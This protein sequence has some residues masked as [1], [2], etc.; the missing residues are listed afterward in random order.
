MPLLRRHR[1]MVLAAR[2]AGWPDDRPLWTGSC[3]C[4]PFSRRQGRRPSGRTPPL[5]RLLRLIRAR[6]P[7]VV[8]GEQVAAAVG[9]HWLDGVCADLEGIGY[10]CGAAVVPACAVDAPHRRDRLWF[11][12]DAVWRSPN[13]V[14]SKGG[15]RLGTGQVQLVH[16]AKQALWSTPRASDG[17]KGGPN[18]SFGAGGQPLP[19]QAF[20]SL[21]A[22]TEKPGA[23]NPEFVSWLMGFPPE[24]GNCAP[25][26]MPSSRK[27]RLKSSAPT[28]TLDLE[29]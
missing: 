2:L 14:D 22:E 6:R 17:E 1:R 25:T 9:K 28:S 24:W 29:S 3:P 12:A 15:N 7:D 16:Q 4:Q 21:P 8:M 19:S 23:L 5:A 13:V 20:H 27:S 26:A 18:Q 10:A 11:V